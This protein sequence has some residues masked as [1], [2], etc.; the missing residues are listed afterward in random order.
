V[1]GDIKSANILIDV[2]FRAK[3]A[4]F[5]LTR[6]GE[7]GV[8][9][10]PYWMAPELLT[11][12]TNTVESD[13]YAFGITLWEV[14]SREMPYMNMT[15]IRALEGVVSG[16]RPTIPALTPECI[17]SMIERCWSQTASH[18]PDAQQ[19]NNE[20]RQMESRNIRPPAQLKSLLRMDKDDSDSQ[21]STLRPLTR[22]PFCSFNDMAGGQIEPCQHGDV[23]VLFAQV[24][25]LPELVATME[26]HKISGMFHRLFARFDKLAKE[27]NV[28][29]GAC[30]HKLKCTWPHNQ[31]FGLVLA[32]ASL[33]VPSHCLLLP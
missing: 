27:Y 7:L 11:G 13:V 17:Q 10:T 8:S 30:H 26:P 6:Q 12:G 4:D 21:N 1:H 18:R 24:I 9:G 33:H 32:W 14:Y 3:V 20:F 19:L 16:T 2:N 28:F 29:Q 5:G 22:T 25:G 31:N 15:P 23:S